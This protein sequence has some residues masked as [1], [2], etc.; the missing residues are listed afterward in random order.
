MKEKSKYF[1]ILII[2]N[3]NILMFS[4]IILLSRISYYIDKL[5]SHSFTN[6]IYYIPNSIYITLGISLAVNIYFINL[7]KK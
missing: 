1:Y 7:I 6:P 4:L 2:L 3:I 5:S